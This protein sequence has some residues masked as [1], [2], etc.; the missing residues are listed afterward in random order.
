MRCTRIQSKT[1]LMMNGRKERIEEV[2]CAF[3]TKEAFTRQNSA[4]EEVEDFNVCLANLFKGIVSD[5]L[6]TTHSTSVS[7]KNTPVEPVI[8]SYK[9]NQIKYTK[10]LPLIELLVNSAL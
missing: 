6:S 3:L 7:L 8:P 10:A 2:I 1:P 4:F 5:V 9:M